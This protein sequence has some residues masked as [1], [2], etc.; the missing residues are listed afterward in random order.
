MNLKIHWL[1]IKYPLLLSISVYSICILLVLLLSLILNFSIGD[2]SFNK[3]LNGWF[4]IF[5][6][7]LKIDL[8]IILGG[9][10]FSVPS[11]ILIA[12]NGFLLGGIL[13]QG[14]INNEIVDLLLTIL[15][16]GIVET[17]GFLLSS[18][19]AIEITI[20][21][22]FKKIWDKKF[23]YYLLIQLSICI[24]FCLISAIIEG[25]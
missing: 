13:G 14:I 9:F 24:I 23:S 15:P 6:H 16:H 18:C 4:N 19:I 2:M 8:I 10:F 7:N 3:N 11:I 17:I 25:A 5:L 21:L 20:Q 1:Y 12:I 22:F